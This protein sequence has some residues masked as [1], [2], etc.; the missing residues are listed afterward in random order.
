MYKYT[1]GELLDK[2]LLEHK[3]KEIEL[4]N[5]IIAQAYWHGADGG[6]GYDSNEEDLISSINCWLEYKKYSDNYIV[7]AQAVV[8]PSADSIYS[9]TIPQIV[10][11]ELLNADE[12]ERAVEPE[13]PVSVRF[14]N[15]G[16]H[17]S[18][19]N[20]KTYQ[21]V[22]EFH[23]G[24]AKKALY[25][26]E[27]E[28]NCVSLMDVLEKLM[29][30]QSSESTDTIVWLD[31]KGRCKVMYVGDYKWRLDCQSNSGYIHT[32]LFSHAF[33]LDSYTRLKFALRN[34]RG[35]SDSE[36]DNQNSK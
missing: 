16:G 18:D 4:V 2:L 9:Y 10:N 27:N 31:T 29:S 35:E 21:V 32:Y 33:I 17:L 8:K 28:H 6:G 15:A 1:G 25:W 19:P 34:Q 36:R 3:E 24:I 20:A 13:Y 26:I 14:Q 12:E 23:E 7:D 11:K 30:I 5:D 22:V